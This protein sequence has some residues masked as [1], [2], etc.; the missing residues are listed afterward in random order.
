MDKFTT[1]RRAA[2]QSKV[3]AW[4]FIAGAV[5]L[6]AVIGFLVGPYA[7][8][9]LLGDGTSGGRAIV[10]VKTASNIVI[11]ALLVGV[12]LG[13]LLN[14]TILSPG[15]RHGAMTWTAV[16]VGAC[17]LSIAPM[18]VARG[19]EADRLGY[20][21]RLRQSL[22]ESRISA[23]K[24]ENDYARRMGLL[25]RSQGVNLYTLASASGV[26]QS[27][28]LL[29]GQK[30][31]LADARGAY[32]KGQDD[33]RAFLAKAIVGQADREAVLLRFDEARAERTPLMQKVFSLQERLIALDE[34]QID[35][36]LANR[37]KWRPSY[38]GGLVSDRALLNRLNAMN[39]EREAMLDEHDAASD[40]I[41]ELDARTEAGIDRIIFAA[42]KV[43]R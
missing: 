24:A 43:D 25:Q 39:R 12:S 35:L 17:A 37:S 5:V 1:R 13:M 36:L 11:P 33:A 4:P 18:A 2:W 27:R 21:L 14:T 15:G 16:L 32:T 6:A 20:E 38:G 3:P 8:G 19:I 23:Q 31:L 34:A 26:E 29:A 40:K 28:K 7:G 22:A 42:A 9:M 41:R 10:W 30:D